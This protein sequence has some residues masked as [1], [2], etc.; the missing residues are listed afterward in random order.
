MLQQRKTSSG[1]ARCLLRWG[2]ARQLAR[3]EDGAAAVEF[4][5]VVAPFLALLFAIMETSLI[6]FAQQTLEKA[7]TD[8]ARQIMTGQQQTS[9]ATDTPQDAYRKFKEK[10]CGPTNPLPM[11]S[12]AADKM[13]IDVQTY[14]FTSFGSAQTGKPTDPNFAG[15]YNPGGPGCIVVVRVIY[16]WP[17]FGIGFS[18]PNLMNINFSVADA[19]GGGVRTLISTA[20]FRNEPY[21]TQTTC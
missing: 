11:F 1:L 19:Q 18:L 9:T 13:I 7:T 20:V 4:A 16:K 10:I 3:K 15:S 8:A 14:G 21:G 17:V 5:L 12:C 2:F 6:F